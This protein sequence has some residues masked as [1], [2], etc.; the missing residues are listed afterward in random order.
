[1]TPIDNSFSSSV[2]RNFGPASFGNSFTNSFGTSPYMSSA[3]GSTTPVDPPPSWGT[4]QA[5]DAFNWAH[6]PPQMSA[7]QQ[8]QQQQQATDDMTD[9]LDPQ[10]FNSLAELLIQSQNSTQSQQQYQQQL[11]QIHQQQQQQQSQQQQQESFDLLSALAQAQSQ[12]Q[13]Q[14]PM[15]QQQVGSENG[16]SASLLTR[17]MQQAQAQP[18][19]SRPNSV[20]GSA[21]GTP[22]TS[23][24]PQYSSPTYVNQQ[25]TMLDP[26]SMGRFPTPPQT[27]SSSFQQQNGRSIKSSSNPTTPWPVQDRQLSYSGTPVTTP[28]GSEYAYTS[29]VEVG[30]TFDCENMPLISRMFLDPLEPHYPSS[31][32][33][34]KHLF[35]Q[36]QLSTRPRVRVAVSDPRTPHSTAPCSP[37]PRNQSASK[38]CQNTSQST[39]AYR[40]RQGSNNQTIKTDILA[41]SCRLYRPDLIWDS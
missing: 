33:A 19:Y 40:T 7:P 32:V 14:Q 15:P 41:L 21:N 23:T 35:R 26:A 10:V 24:T 25:Q 17:R 36:H 1:M 30:S 11:P 12:M 29:P 3:N 4:A 34:E 8:R 38:P 20:G 9:M 22:N 37:V 16:N 2:G 27:F 31:L 5:T 28:G 18:Q 13:S 6:M 39:R